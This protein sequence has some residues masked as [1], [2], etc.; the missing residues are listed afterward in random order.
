MVHEDYL[1]CSAYVG[2]PDHAESGF[3]A[4]FD[5]ESARY[6]FAAMDADGKVLLKSE[7]YPQ[8]AA[9]DNGI[10]SVI[11]NRGN[12][13]Y[14]SVKE[15]DGR[16][17][18]SLRA[19]NYREIARSCSCA[20][21]AEAMALMPYVTGEQVRKTVV[22][23]LTNAEVAGA[24]RANDRIDDDYL[25][26]REY[27]NKTNVGI[28]GYPD[29]VSF[30]HTNGKYYFAWYD[31][32]DG[33][34]LMRSEGYPTTAARD[35]GM[36][37]V[38]K[39]R[40]LEERYA[41][42]EKMG[43]YFVILKAGNH[44]EIARSC[45]YNSRAEAEAI[46]PASRA[47]AKSA[48]AAAAAVVVEMPKVEIPT[49]TIAP[50]EVPKVTIPT[51][52][53]APIEVPKVEVAIDAE[54]DYLMCRE[55]KG[56]TDSPHKGFRTF[57]SP[58]TG[59]FYFTVVEDN[60]DVS[61]RS[62]GHLTAAERDT[63]MADV[64][65]NM[66]IP[67]RYDTKKV[68]MD[69]YFIV[70]RDE[71]GK[72]IA[73]SCAYTDQPEIPTKATIA[74]VVVAAAAPVIAPVVE[75]P[76]VDVE[77]DYLMCREYKGHTAAPHKGFRTFKSD[78]T[79]KFYFAVVEDNGDVSMRSEGHLTASDRDADMADVV[80]NM[81]VKERYDV[82]QVGFDHYFIVLHDEKGK[83]IARSCAYKDKAAIYAVAPFMDTTPKPKIDVAPIAVA[84]AAAV[85]LPKLE[86]PK[87]EVPKVKIPEVKVEV[88]K[89]KVPE[90]KIEVPKVKVPEVKV[91]VPKITVPKVVIP[92]AIVESETPKVGFNWWWLLPLLLTGL[93]WMLWGKSCNADVPAVTM[94]KIEVPTPAIETPKVKEVAPI[95]PSC[96]LNWI[97]FDYDK[98]NIR[99]DASAELA[100]M[101]KI[102]KANKEYVGVLSA[103]TDGKGTEEYNKA[104]SAR[105]AAAAKAALVG[106]GVEAARLTTAAESKDA[107]IAQNTVDDS[108]RKFNR[109][110][111]LYVKDKTGKN[112]CQSIAPEV[113]T[114]LKGK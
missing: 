89:V 32:E 86:I 25:A 3:T 78:R 39:N 44:Q 29:V 74:P 10:Q 93:A 73:R 7:G 63:D 33:D 46:F 2:H 53:V 15:S 40:E 19:A 111:E 103:H 9:R 102:L 38:A 97:F 80:R 61:L 48:R 26:C 54:D 42:L 87:V 70:L 108:G 107:P 30:Q 96:D 110:V 92:E 1:R 64:V 112:I 90:V 60:G 109:R 13:D 106:M 45:G 58:R 95:A 82:K 31:D 100:T 41:I 20:T 105:R 79:G 47:A 12:R 113:P 81:L 65:R 50:I 98:S 55:Y 16:Y 14:Y 104:L 24:D 23:T 11:K 17:H 59:K 114:A 35:N 99:A 22:A 68:G 49:V 66:L 4:F 34:V 72:E 5:T 85:V 76:A 28:G 57:K 91:E 27:A 52:T 36:A 18:L 67:E 56:H 62:E 77:D 43:R 37:S 51:V 21:E 75:V 94:P 84:A 71:K 6:F 8:V 88:P 69:H 83:E 101:A